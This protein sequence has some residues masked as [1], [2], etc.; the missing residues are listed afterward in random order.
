MSVPVTQAATNP[1]SD[2]R[3]ARGSRTN[4]SR[5]GR[6]GVTEPN[7]RPTVDAAVSAQ[8]NL[9][10]RIRNETNKTPAGDVHEDGYCRNIERVDSQ[11]KV[12]TEDVP[13]DPIHRILAAV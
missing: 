9:P 2:L 13:Y 8:D 4:G 11:R 3:G 5:E 6:R 12:H 10:I 7:I 1:A